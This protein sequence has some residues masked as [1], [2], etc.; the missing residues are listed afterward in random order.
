MENEADECL[1]DDVNNWDRPEDHGGC[2]AYITVTTT[3]M[4]DWKKIGNSMLLTLKITKLKVLN[5]SSTDT[6]FRIFN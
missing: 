2:A 1:E 3:T 5:Y 6:C 4:K